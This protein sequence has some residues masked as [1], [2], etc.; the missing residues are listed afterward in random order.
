MSET[1]EDVEH[2][3]PITTK[4]EPMLFTVI[5]ADRPTASG[6]RHIPRQTEIVNIGRGSAR[7]ASRSGKILE[8]RF[9]SAAMSSSHADLVREKGDWWVVDRG[10][11][12]GTFLNH[13][14]IQKS[15]VSDG[16]V[17]ELGRTFFVF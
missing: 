12:N 16:D 8:L 11:K 14:R 5:E 4:P 3:R 13:A 10:S 9:E 1:I 2:S 15:R 7:S 6:G 17:I